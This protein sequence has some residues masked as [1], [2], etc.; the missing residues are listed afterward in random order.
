MRLFYHIPN[1]SDQ[2][3]TIY[4]D[5]H[6]TSLSSDRQCGEITL[7]LGTVPGNIFCVLGVAPRL[8]SIGG[9]GTGK[10]GVCSW[11]TPLRAG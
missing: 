10:K 11:S 2:G 6:Y 4:F 1:P 3:R 7:N 8:N 5:Q 9:L